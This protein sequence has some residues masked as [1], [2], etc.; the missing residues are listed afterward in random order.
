MARTARAK[1]PARALPQSIEEADEL[2]VRLGAIQRT[3]ALNKLAFD[4]AQA[5]ARTDFAEEDAPLAEAEKMLTEDIAAW[6]SV[7]RNAETDG[8]QT[9][10]IKLPSGGVLKWRLTPSKVTL[11][12]V[13]AVIERLRALELNRFLREKTE[14]DKDAML[15]EPE[16]AKAIEGVKI[17]QKEEFII[18]PA[19]APEEK[20]PAIKQDADGTTAS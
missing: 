13:A 16:V 11:T 5:S 9:K 4:E 6:A 19:G 15:K 3:R 20:P 10:T 18:E 17:S 12:G 8:G 7:N 2:V 1:T 14:V